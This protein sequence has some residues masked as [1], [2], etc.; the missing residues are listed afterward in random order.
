M[1]AGW[2]STVC[3]S[4]APSSNPCSPMGSSRSSPSRSSSS[5]RSRWTSTWSAAV[6]LNPALPPHGT[7]HAAQLEFFHAQRR[8]ADVG[9]R[10]L[11]HAIDVREHADGA[12]VPAKVGHGVCDLP[13]F[14]PEHAVAREARLEQ[15]PRVDAQK[16]SQARVAMRPRSTQVRGSCGEP[17]SAQGAP[18]AAPAAGSERIVTGSGNSC[19]PSFVCPPAA[20][21]KLEIWHVL[22]I[23]GASLAK[24][25]ERWMT[26][27]SAASSSRFIVADALRLPNQLL[28]QLPSFL[29]R[30]HHH[31]APIFLPRIPAVHRRAR[32]VSVAKL[33][34]R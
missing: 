33:N 24:C 28:T 17:P 13:V 16:R 6:G 14:D 22:R 27:F 4:S 5:G 19:W 31:R 7:R 21:K 1:N 29:W 15:R 34:P 25:S 20:E 30:H 8:H 18:G 2:V 9:G 11:A 32:E 3:P 10:A 12:I 26:S 23:F